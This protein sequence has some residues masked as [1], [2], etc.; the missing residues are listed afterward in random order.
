MSETKQSASQRI[1]YFSRTSFV[2]MSGLLSFRPEGE[3][4]LM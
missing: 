2:M 4:L 1:D 3:I